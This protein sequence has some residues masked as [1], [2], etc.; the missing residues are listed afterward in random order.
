MPIVGM[1]NGVDGIEC[2]KSCKKVYGC[3][4]GVDDGEDTIDAK[5]KEDSSKMMCREMMTF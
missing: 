5:V 4:E 2:S 3:K 1:V